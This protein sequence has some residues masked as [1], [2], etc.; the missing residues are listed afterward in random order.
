MIDRRTQ[1]SNLSGGISIAAF[2]QRLKALKTTNH[3][4]QS[5]KTKISWAITALKQKQD[6]IPIEEIA[7]SLGVSRAWIKEINEDYINSELNELEARKEHVAKESEPVD[8]IT[9]ELMK[10]KF[11][12]P[13]ID[14]YKK[15]NT[16]TFST[17]IEIKELIRGINND[18]SD[19]ELCICLG[20]PREAV[21]NVRKKVLA[22][23]ETIERKLE[24]LGGDEYGRGNK[25]VAIGRVSHIGTISPIS[26][27]K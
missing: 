18:L 2:E 12:V 11:T 17:P 15:R 3:D 22:E 1:Q 13:F 4:S 7:N 6:D 20:C 21:K 24:R 19:K 8:P 16:W 23:M 14:G 9:T 10:R 5:I 27:S 25:T 26:G